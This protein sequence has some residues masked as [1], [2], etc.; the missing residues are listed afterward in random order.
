[1]IDNDVDMTFEE[2]RN[3]FISKKIICKNCLKMV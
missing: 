3:E 1:M 2:Y